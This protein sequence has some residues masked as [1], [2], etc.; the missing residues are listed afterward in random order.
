MQKCK[1]SLLC[2]K[3]KNK[4]KSFENAKQ[5]LLFLINFKKI[6]YFLFIL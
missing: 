4:E 3:F 6:F 2:F 1:M 5:Y